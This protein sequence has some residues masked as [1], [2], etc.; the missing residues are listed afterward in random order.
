[1]LR[2]GDLPGLPIEKLMKISRIPATAMAACSLLT[3][4]SLLNAQEGELLFEDPLNADT[5]ANWS[6]VGNAPEA[7]A[8]TDWLATHAW[9]YSPYGIPLSPNAPVGGETRGLRMDINVS[10]GEEHYIKLTPNGQNFSGNYVLKFDLWLN[11]NG[12]LGNPENPSEAA[13]GW[14]STEY[15]IFGV[16]TDSTTVHQWSPLS[17]SEGVG[18]WFAMPGDGGSTFDYRAFA[19]SVSLAAGEGSPYLARL[20]ANFDATVDARNHFQPFYHTIFPGGVTVINEQWEMYWTSTG[21]TTPGVAG[22]IWNEVAVEVI[23]DTVRWYANDVLIAELTPEN[24]AEAGVVPT[25]GNIFIGYADPFN[26]LAADGEADKDLNFGLFANVRVYSLPSDATGFA[27]WASENIADENARGPM[28]N[29]SGD[30]INNLMKYALG[31]DPAVADRSGLPQGVIED[32]AGQNYLTLTASKNQEATNV[33]LVVEVSGD[34]VTWTSGEG[35]TTVLVDDANTL[36]VRDNTPL[37]GAGRR[38]IR[39]NASMVK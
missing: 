25:D 21:E 37:T 18:G 9:D 31:L 38:F 8:S 14:G 10:T 7:P 39:L 3:V 36:Q 24:T 5:S 22:F 23:G 12:S 29:P 33:E 11:F 2:A 13:G 4:G 16:G 27:G 34:L 17:L 30:G 1:M 19:N 28:D 15:A 26:S 20:D 35:Q 32:H 6:L